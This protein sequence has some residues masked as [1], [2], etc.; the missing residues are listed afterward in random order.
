[1]ADIRPDVRTSTT[2]VTVGCKLPNGL[3]MELPEPAAGRQLL[4]GPIGER[5]VLAGANSKLVKTPI[6]FVTSGTYRYGVTQVPKEFAEAWFARHKDFDFVKRGMVFMVNNEASA[7]AAAKERENDAATRT[8]LEPLGEKD[9]R[10]PKG[11]SRN[12]QTEADAA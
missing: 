3:V 6:G 8:G 5:H 2:T 11:V 1:M 4:P 7:N 12:K 9:S 10:L